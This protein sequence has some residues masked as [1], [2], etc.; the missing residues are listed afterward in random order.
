MTPY[1][2]T[3]IVGMATSIVIKVNIIVGASVSQ[4]HPLTDALNKTRL[5]TIVKITDNEFMEQVHSFQFDI[6]GR[7]IN[8]NC[9]ILLVAYIVVLMLHGHTNVKLISYEKEVYIDNK[10]GNNMRIT[11]ISN[12][13]FRP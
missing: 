4:H 6:L 11:D 10:L 7:S 12:H 2:N 8:E 5:I 9:C 13:T 3:D 1:Y